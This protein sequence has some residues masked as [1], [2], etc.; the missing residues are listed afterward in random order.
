MNNYYQILGVE[1][2]AAP[3]EI[4]RAYKRLAKLHH[5]DV[6][7]GSKQSEVLFKQVGMA[8]QTLSDASTREAYD[9]RLN[10]RKEVRADD[11]NQ[12]SGMKKKNEKNPVDTTVMF[13]K[14]F[15]IKKK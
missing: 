6:N 7:T 12:N 8:Y 11:S 2:N 15:G 9:A 1:S 13:E 3:D 10:A 5:P 4:K 14:Y